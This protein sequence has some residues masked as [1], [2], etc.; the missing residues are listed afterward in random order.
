MDGG[1][2][3]GENQNNALLKTEKSFS[4]IPFVY[5][6]ILYT[7]HN[8][9]LRMRKTQSSIKGK[10][11]ISLCAKWKDLERVIA[12]TRLKQQHRQQQQQQT[13]N[14]PLPSPHAKNPCF[15]VCVFT[16]ILPHPQ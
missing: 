2:C 1:R 3:R 5:V 7:I 12:Q 15:C 10:P 16:Q 8:K 9:Y 13:P 6:S 11:R 14:R 4:F